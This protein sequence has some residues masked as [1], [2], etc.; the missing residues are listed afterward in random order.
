MQS[1][2]GTLTMQA[3]HSSGSQKSVISSDLQSTV[4]LS[5]RTLKITL[6]LSNLMPDERR[7]Y[8]S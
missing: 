5:V 2:A 4:L 8:A 3:I 6:S 1:D 7:F